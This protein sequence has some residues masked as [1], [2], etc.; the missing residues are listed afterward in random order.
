MVKSEGEHLQVDELALVVL[1]GEK[2]VAMV[3]EGNI[4]CWASTGYFFK[5]VR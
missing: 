4:G 3:W 1:H 2:E 5:D